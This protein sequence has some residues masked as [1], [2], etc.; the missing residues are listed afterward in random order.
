MSKSSNKQKIQ[1][2]ELWL[3]N[4]YSIL[5]KKDPKRLEKKTNETTDKTNA[6]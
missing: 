3:K 6:D 1:C 4:H 5:R 2:L